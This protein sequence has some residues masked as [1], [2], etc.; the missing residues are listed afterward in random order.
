MTEEINISNVGNFINIETVEIS[1][2]SKIIQQ[3]LKY[4]PFWKRLKK[5]MCE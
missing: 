1:D 3:M 4:Y 2:I 5:V